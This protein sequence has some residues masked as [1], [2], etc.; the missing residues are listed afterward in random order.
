MCI[1]SDSQILRLASEGKLIAAG[2]SE[3]S[4]TPNGYDLRVSEVMLP[5]RSKESSGVARIPSLSRFAVSTIEKVL[6]PADITAQLWLRSSYARR[7]IMGS[8]GKVDAG[9][10]GTLTLSFFNS[11]SE[12]LMLERGDRITQIVF[13]KMCGE[14]E[15]G[16]DSRSGHYQNQSEIR[17]E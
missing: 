6:L 14:A 13:E 4:L 12:E 2:F 9:F 8:F 16:Y 7:G 5:D 3:Q 11:S 15:R 1:L 10:F 17:L